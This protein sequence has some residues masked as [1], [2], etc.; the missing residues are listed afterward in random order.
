MLKHPRRAQRSDSFI[1]WTILLMRALQIACGHQELIDDLPAR[2]Y[3]CLLPKLEH[4]N[5]EKGIVLSTEIILQ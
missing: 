4:N 3:K 5:Y 1:H 2:E